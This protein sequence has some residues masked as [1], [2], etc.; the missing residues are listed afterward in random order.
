MTSVQQSRRKQF[1]RR[2]SI[3]WRSAYLLA[4]FGQPALAL[5]EPGSDESKEPLEP[6]ISV[7]QVGLELSSPLTRFRGFSVDMDYRT[8]QGDLPEANDQTGFR[9]V[10]TPSWPIKLSNE[11]FLFLRAT[12]PVFGDQPYWKPVS[13]LDYAEF[14]IR[15]L[16]SIDETTGG[17]SY[18][19]DH[20]GDIGI[21][22]GYGGVNENGFISMVGI[23]N[24]APTSEDQSARRGQWLIGPELA[25]GQVTSWGLFGGR[26]KHLT[27]IDGEG[28]QEV[29]YDTNETTLE[30]FF[31]YALGNGWQIESNPIILY[32]WEAVSGNEWSIPVGVGVSKTFMSGSRPIKLG[33]EVQNFVVSADRFGPEWLIGF[34]LTPVFSTQLLR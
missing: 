11:K 6:A 10:F 28:A 16:P 31:A 19:H 1:S 14:L 26:A 23:A 32:D 24:V 8:Y 2:I 7:D 34:N 20:L 30:L 9:M 27:N 5:A 4:I 15:Q 29:S 13:Y 18:G 21:D 3:S 22:I 25:L 33:L 12:I 17:F